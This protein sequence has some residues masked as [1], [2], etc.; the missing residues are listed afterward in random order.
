[1]FKDTKARFMDDQEKELLEGFRK[2]KPGYKSFIMSTA[3]TVVIHESV[4]KRQYGLP[5]ENI[6]ARWLQNPDIKRGKGI[7][8]NT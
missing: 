3:A 7:F 1:M 2:L 6:P 5:V 4:F 8:Q